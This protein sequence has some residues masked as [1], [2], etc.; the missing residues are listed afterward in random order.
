MDVLEIDDPESRA[1]LERRRGKLHLLIGDSVARYSGMRS[2]IIADRLLNLSRGGATWASVAL[3]L[4]ELMDEWRRVAAAEER[5]LGTAV[6]WLTGND[7][8]DRLSGLPSFTDESLE[9]AAQ[10]AVSVVRQL[11]RETE[12]ILVLGPLPRMSGEVMGGR[13]ERTSAY[14]LERRL[15]HRLPGPVRFL[16][17]GRQLTKK[18][19][20]RHSVTAECAK[21]Y[22]SDGTHLSREGYEKIADVLPVWLTMV[23]PVVCR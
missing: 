21:W 19:H 10:N 17:L 8:Y 4:P 15:T 14:H 12:Q 11:G 16:Q 20:N 1:W 9:C 3:Q 6:V 23:E 2:R 18:L 13:W 22:S 7:V 5:R